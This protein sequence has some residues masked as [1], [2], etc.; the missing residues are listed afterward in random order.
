MEKICILGAGTYG[1]YLAKALSEKFPKSHIKLVDVGGSK[2]QS[3]EKVGFLSSLK[4]ADY[5][6]VNKG[7]FF[8]LGG[9]SN[10]WAG[11]LLFFSKHDCPGEKG[12]HTIR[13]ANITYKDTV[14]R[15]FFKEAPVLQDR[16]IE[17]GLFLKQGIW[18][19]QS[20]RNFFKHLRIN[21]IKNVDIVK[22]A[23]V[24]KLNIE[25]DQLN[26]VTIKVGT[27]IEELGADI[28]YLACGAFE[29]IRL[30]SVAGL[31]NL[32]K[33]TTGFRD[34]VSL[35]GFTILD[36]K[37]NFL[38]HDL[39]HMFVNNSLI[40]SRII[41]H[42]KNSSFYLKAIFNNEFLLVRELKNLV[43]RRNPFSFSQFVKGLK[44][45]H[46]IFPF[47]FH[48]LYHKK[49]YVYKN[50]DIFIDIELD[51]NKNK[52]KLSEETDKFGEAGL[53]IF[54]SIPEITLEKLKAAKSIVKSILI[55]NGVKFREAD[56]DLSVSE[57]IDT[58]HPYNFYNSDGQ[59]TFEEI[60]NPAK[61]LFV[62]HTGILKRICGNNP[63]ASLLCLIEKHI[64]EDFSPDLQ[65]KEEQ[66][67]QVV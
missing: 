67:L 45:A 14:L 19:K 48:Y 13:N 29:S 24:V 58:L 39:G 7:R 28:F 38:N 10:K 8:G 12:M 64:A 42:S 4:G 26:S 32:E 52:I 11:Q 31:Y 9:T 47:A 46:H 40:T 51:E 65:K 56:E 34:R 66:V 17:E 1:S 53:D 2:V 60:F 3:E 63:T 18:L 30:L 20:Q 61:K 41:A 43:M 49:L 36:T 62:L 27:E 37:A 21:S 15:R 50:W 23:R 33:I 59:L 57:I 54:F 55:K 5:S 35:K 6:A 25:N 44:V 16:E 22:E